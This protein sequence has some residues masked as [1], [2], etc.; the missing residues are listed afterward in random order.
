LGS[1]YD[2]IILGLHLLII[3]VKERGPTNFTFLMDRRVDRMIQ[4]INVLHKRD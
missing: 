2:D 3:L 1:M 4:V